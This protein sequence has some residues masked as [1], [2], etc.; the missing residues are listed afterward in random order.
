MASCPAYST[1]PERASVAVI[2]NNK[3][4]H[5]LLG[6]GQ[7]ALPIVM[8]GEQDRVTELYLPAQYRLRE[9]VDQ[10]VT[11]SQ[12][13]RIVIFQ[14]AVLCFLALWLRTP[15]EFS[16]RHQ[17]RHKG[18]EKADHHAAAG[19]RKAFRRRY[20]AWRGLRFLT[21]SSEEGSATYLGYGETEALKPL[22]FGWPW[23]RIW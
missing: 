12:G 20:H 2:Q 6:V 21:P 14:G 17:R 7:S 23:R 5:G 4:S 3:A 18:V 16:N 19:T 1:E 9:L 11:A 8:S 13:E 10:R 22:L 15:A